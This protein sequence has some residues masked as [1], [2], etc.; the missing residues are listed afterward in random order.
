MIQSALYWL[1]PGY[2]NELCCWLLWRQVT[3]GLRWQLAAAP[4]PTSVTKANKWLSHI[5]ANRNAVSGE[6]L[7]SGR[8]TLIGAVGGEAVW[9]FE[10]AKVDLL[11]RL[12]LAVQADGLDLDDVI[13][14]L[15]QVPE[16]AR[17]AGGVDFP[18]ES[19]RVAF[20][21]LRI[22]RGVKDNTMDRSFE[23]SML[24]E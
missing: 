14:L 17:A 1:K 3:H 7:F 10:G 5:S 11:A 4:P 9:L 8:L 6:E 19:L 18:N 21:P 2:S 24:H 15:L 20:L 16:H 13:G 12:A 23:Q 22:N